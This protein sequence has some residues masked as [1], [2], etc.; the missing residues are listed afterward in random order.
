MRRFAKTIALVSLTFLLAIACMPTATP[1]PTNISIFIPTSEVTST[2]TPS[3]TPTSTSIPPTLTPTSRPTKTPA[4]TATPTSTPI[5]L[6]E[7]FHPAIPADEVLGGIERLCSSPD[8]G[9]WAITEEGI[10]KL[11]DGSW[12]L[13]LSDYTGEL[14]GIDSSGRVW[15]LGEDGGEISAWNGGDWTTYGADEGWTP[16]AESWYYYASGGQSDA[17][18]RLWFATSQDVRVFDG[19]RWIVFSPEDMGMG[20]PVGEDLDIV[21]GVAI[22]ESGAVWVREC[23]W[24]GPGPF[25]GRGVRWFEGSVWHGADSPVASGCATEI[26]ED[27]AGNV[28]L[29]VEEKLW[30]YDPASG[31]WTEF[32]PPEPP[33]DGRFGF[34]DSLAVD[35]SG[36][37]WPMIVICGGASCYGN[38]ALYHVHDG[39]WTQ[40]GDVA[41]YDLQWGPFFG[42]DGAPWVF[43]GWGVY[44]IVEDTP[45]FMA[46][47]YARSVVT[48]GSG[49]VWFLAWYEGRDWLWML[50]I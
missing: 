12:S 6:P 20:P 46:P 26:V 36:D 10:A 43:W 41:E 5:P 15:V 38:V 14:A 17:L 18:G 13:Y 2:S 49:R 25:G 33:I 29:G 4:P 47:L 27:G 32:A 40:I 28:W 42:A 8:G 9:L 21:F 7:M 39:A 45:E 3:L 16:L 50:D 30:R 44:R 34:L 37:P 35:P 22:L 1:L 31:A 19:E 48:D 24:G 23:E 11:E